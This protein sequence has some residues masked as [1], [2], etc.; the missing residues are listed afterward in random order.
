MYCDTASKTAINFPKKEGRFIQ[1][2][3]FK[4]TSIISVPC[5][6]QL[7][8]AG[9]VLFL[10]C[11]PTYSGSLPVHGDIPGGG[12]GWHGAH[13]RGTGTGVDGVE[14]CPEGR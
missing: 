10:R 5:V 11:A 3:I 14:G 13:S 7:Q 2:F 9:H 12:R 1:P 4:R 8:L 6:I